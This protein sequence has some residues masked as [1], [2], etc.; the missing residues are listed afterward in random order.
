M[1]LYQFMIAVRT[2]DGVMQS[3]AGVDTRCVYVCM[4]VRVRVCVLMWLALF[5]TCS[6][7][8][9]LGLFYRTVRMI[10]NGLKPVFVFDGKPPTLKS[11]EVRMRCSESRVLA[12]AFLL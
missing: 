7:S 5:R 2:A 10:E 4:C 12:R 8:H 9:L 11:G 6:R 3:A 1:C